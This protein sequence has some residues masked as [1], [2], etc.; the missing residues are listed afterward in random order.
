MIYLLIVASIFTGDLLLKNYIEKNKKL[1]K[2][3]KILK[4]KIIITKYHNQGAFLN[5][6]EKK[7]ELLLLMSGILLGML[8]LGMIFV[9]PQKGK[10][11]LKLGLS[12]MLGGA[13]SN[14][15]DRVKRGYVVDYYSF[16]FFDKVVYNISDMFIFIGSIIVTV[17]LALSE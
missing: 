4:D 17:R 15:Y 9:L 11:L 1:G 12:F 14:V 5:L 6:L 7:R 2:Q 8:S 16:S 10:R 3:E 13:S